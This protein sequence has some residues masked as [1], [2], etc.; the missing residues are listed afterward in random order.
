MG[1]FDEQMRHNLN[2]QGQGGY[3]SKGDA[4]F[5][6][7]YPARVEFVDDP[8]S[9]G[10]IKVRIDDRDRLARDVNDLP[11]CVPLK[12]SFIY[13]KPRLGELVFVLLEDPKDNTGIRY[14]SGPIHTSQFQHKAESYS[15]AKNIYKDSASNSKPQISSKDLKHLDIPKG[16]DVGLEGR[17]DAWVILKPKEVRLVAGAF[18]K[19]TLQPNT[20]T[21]A[22]ISVSQKEN[23]DEDV[24]LKAYSKTDLTSTVINLYSHLGKFRD[25]NIAKFEKNDHLSSFG[26]L[27][28][29]LSPSVK[30]DELIKLLDLIIRL[31]QSHIHTPQRP[32]ATTS[33]SEQLSRYTVDGELQRIISSYV[34]IN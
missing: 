19:G 32:L 12:S 31:L 6:N 30:G 11:W 5:R 9:Q 7:V 20:K 15:S 26:D 21:P 8:L 13:S 28:N 10:R 16:F 25:S 2:I 3:S 18:D 33:L 34:R 22:F 24:E 14:W 4:N 1:G 23:A 29:A 27:A 17:D